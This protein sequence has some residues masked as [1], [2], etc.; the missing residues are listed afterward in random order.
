MVLQRRGEV[1]AEAPA[2][3]RAIVID[4]AHLVIAEAV[5]A[6]FIEEELGVLDEEIAHLGLAE[7]EHKPTGMAF[8]GKIE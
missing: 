1:L 3:G 7:V 2:M 4:D 6:I 5:E 8:V